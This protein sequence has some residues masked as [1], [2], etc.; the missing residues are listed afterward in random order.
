[1]SS[2]S[3]WY[4]TGEDERLPAELRFRG[5]LGLGKKHLNQRDFYAAYDA[6]RRAAS[7]ADDDRYELARGLA[8][9]AAAGFRELN[10]DERGR[11][12]QLSHARRRLAAFRPEAEGLD[13]EALLRQVE[14]RPEV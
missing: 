5:A 1:M 6:F 12:R 3:G 11:A 13:L 2:L 9:L 7:A 10:A 4:R 8:H 14:D